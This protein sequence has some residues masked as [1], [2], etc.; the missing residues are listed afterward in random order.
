LPE[1]LGSR[2]TL[3]NGDQSH[4]GPT[5]PATDLT[6]APRCPTP[7]KPTGTVTSTATHATRRAATPRV[8]RGAPS[9]T[10]SRPAPRPSSF[11]RWQ[12][13]QLQALRQGIPRGGGEAW[14]CARRAQGQ[15]RGVTLSCSHAQPS[16][17]PGV[18]PGLHPPRREPQRLHHCNNLAEL[19]SQLR[20]FVLDPRAF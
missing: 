18:H 9:P 16:P 19:A 7:T 2:E 13:P 17:G 1:T 14:V 4:M 3:H 8:P 5:R 11:L 10:I 20:G 6:T 15:V 12:G